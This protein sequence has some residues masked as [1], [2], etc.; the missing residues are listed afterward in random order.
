[1]NRSFYATLLLFTSLTARAQSPVIDRTDMPA[2]TTAAPVDT[3]RLSVAGPGLPAGAPLLSQ[4]GPAQTW[5][6]AALTPVS[7]QVE[8]YVTVSSVTAT[9]PLYLLYFGP[10]G[11]VNRA[12][13]A[14][15]QALPL[16]PGAPVQVTDS[17]QFYSTTAAAAPAQDFRSVGFGAKLAGTPIPVTYASQAQQDVIYRFPLSYASPRDSSSSFFATPAAASAVGYLS[18]KRKRVNRPDAWGTLITPFGS[19]STVRVVTTLTDHDSVAFGGGPGIGFDLPVTREY[20]WLAKTHHVPLLTITTTLVGSQETIVSIR[21][22]DR[23]RRIVPL[24]AKQEA[25]ALAGVGVYPNPLAAGPLHL[26]GLPGTAALVQATDLTGRRLFEWPLKAGPTE[27][28]IPA[29]ALGSFHGVAL[30]RIQTA[31]AVVVRRV[32]RQ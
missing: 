18:Q 14:S 9:A 8:R 27:A 6:Y 1:M 11:G 19:F 2:P 23:Y 17:Y 22:R 31:R 28:T 13:A 29:A 21:Y 32:V 5:S 25:A 30:L 26:T 24:A 20:K 15:P 4:R 10:L 7:Q 3:L 12:T 16:P